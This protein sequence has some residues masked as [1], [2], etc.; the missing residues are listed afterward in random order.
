LCFGE[1]SGV[2]IFGMNFFKN[3]IVGISRSKED[4]IFLKKL[5]KIIEFKPKNLEFYKEAFT[6]RGTNKTDKNGNPTSYERLE[7]L[8]DS[9][10]GSI[11][12]SYLF[13][14]IPNQNEG[15]LTKMK[16]KIVSRENLN[17]IGK[18][19]NLVDLIVKHSKQRRVSTSIYGDIFEALVGAIYMDKGY[20]VCVKFIHKKLIEPFDIQRLEK[21][22]ISHKG[23]L[24]EWCQK[25]KKNYTIKV[26]EIRR[27]SE[28]NFFL[29]SLYIDEKEVAKAQA[30]SKKKAEEIA[31]KR[32]YFSLK[33]KVK[34]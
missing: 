17:S 12:A 4:K 25:Y 27:S 26:E 18:K 9:I 2:V 13:Q 1:K 31:S 10:I 7:F 24:I 5:R 29:I 20:A 14:K 6:H 28:R 8:G 34:S 23:L 3:I 22:I 33:M 32:A 21:K 19:L 16:S 30:T 15:Y 11:I